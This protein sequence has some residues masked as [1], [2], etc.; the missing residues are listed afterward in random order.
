[1]DNKIIFTGE[2]GE[3]V[4]LFIIEEA[5]L[6][7][8]SYLL[9]TDDEDSEEAEA[10]IMRQV[11]GSDSKELDYEFVEDEKE[12]KAISVLFKELIDDDTELV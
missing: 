1:M 10:Y 5:R 3:E 9:V 4:E 2:N 12:L 7:G 11:E 6:N 8:L